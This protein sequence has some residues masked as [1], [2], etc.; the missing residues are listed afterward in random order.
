MA[1]LWNISTQKPEI[2]PLLALIPFRAVMGRTDFAVHISGP[3]GTFKTETAALLARWFNPALN[4]RNAVVNWSGTANALEVIGYYGKDVILIVDD[5][6]P[7]GSASQV[8]KL[9]EVAD[10]LI[11]SAANAAGRTRL[12][13]GST[14]QESRYPRCL[15]LSTGEDIP[16]GES[17]RARM[18]N[19]EFDTG[20]IDVQRLTWLQDNSAGFHRLLTS[21]IRWLQTKPI[22]HRT[23]QLAT[24]ELGEG[25]KRHVAAQHQLEQVARMVGQFGQEVFGIDSD[26]IDI[27]NEYYR[28]QLSVVIEKQVETTREER[29]I[30][31]YIN[32]LR[33][34]LAT[35]KANIANRN[36]GE[37]S[38]PTAMG[39]EWMADRHVA[40]GTRVGW[41]IADEQVLFISPEASWAV[42][43]SHLRSSGQLPIQVAKNTLWKRMKDDGLLVRFDEGRERNTI[44]ISAEGSVKSC[45]AIPLDI[46]LEEED[47]ENNK[48][49]GEF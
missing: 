28:Q 18:I 22:E 17:L 12:T 3:S 26:T 8:A 33:E 45:I 6:A 44:R 36:G 37:P 11:R 43:Q 1:E 49:D 46:I 5:Y 29:H 35:K 42:V 39:W 41:E 34:L 10:R 48:K 9:G 32:T 40:R 2:G 15:I 47:K 25:H 20:D 13:S 38:R 21:F 23:I 19:L 30:D 4:A 31:R 27:A 14:L 7:H 24:R 16:P